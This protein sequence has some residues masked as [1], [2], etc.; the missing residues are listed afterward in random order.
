MTDK[1]IKMDCPFCGT[2]KDKIE[3]TK[4]GSLIRIHCPTCN[5]YFSSSSKQD[6][7]DSWNR[8]V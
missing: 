8:R 2:T 1:R 3:L 6:A 5:V 4:F 7:I